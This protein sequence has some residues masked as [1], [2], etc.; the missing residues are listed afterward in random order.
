MR[1]RILILLS[2]VF[3][4]SMG[5]KEIAVEAG[6]SRFKYLEVSENLKEDLYKINSGIVGLRYKDR[7]SV[8]DLVVSLN[9]QLPYEVFLEDLYG[10]DSRN[11][12]EGTSYFGLNFQAGALYPVVESKV[13]VSAG[14]LFNFDHFYFKDTYNDPNGEYV[15]SVF[16]N[17]IEIDLSYPINYGYKVGVTSSFAGNY[18]M[19]HE[20]GDE[21]KWSYNM[22]FGAYVS[23]S[24][25]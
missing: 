17:A 18:L 19:L 21:F 2:F 10:E 12:L 5:A 22:I 20:R 24:M 14:L 23:Y 4:S 13:H 6:I 9:A 15:F 11:Y 8:V 16:G 7:I 1:S 3:I 25:D